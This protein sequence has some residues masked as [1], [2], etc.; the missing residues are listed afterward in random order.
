MITFDVMSDDQESHQ[1]VW[2]SAGLGVRSR[3]LVARMYSQPE[4]DVLRFHWGSPLAIRF[5]V[6]RPAFSG[7]LEDGDVYGGPQYEPLLDIDVPG[8]L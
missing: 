5:S 1:Q 6:P 8:P 3:E 4:E 7:D 2:A